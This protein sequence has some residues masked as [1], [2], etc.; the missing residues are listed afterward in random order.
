[1][2]V[3]EPCWRDASGAA[4][5]ELPWRVILPDDTT[6][7]DPS[8]WSEDAEVLAATGWQRSVLTAED[9]AALTPPPPP[10]PPGWTTPAGWRLP[11]TPEAVA[12][13]TGLYVLATRREQ[14]RIPQT[15][16]VSDTAGERHA[17]TFA[18]FDS[19]MLSFGAT[20]EA[21]LVTT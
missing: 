14:L 6:R 19:L 2:N 17:M 18:E 1:V 13:L 16:T 7:T 5:L 12:L 3:G 10:E 8:Q 21:A 15:I 11:A 20:M 9:I 4:V